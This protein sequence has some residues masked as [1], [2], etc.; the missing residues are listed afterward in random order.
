MLHKL[1][2]TLL[3]SFI[4]ITVFGQ[5]NIIPKPVSFEQNTDL[6]MLDQN[7]S[8]D[9]ETEI[10]Q[11][12]TYVNEFKTF[13]NNA[14]SRIEYKNVEAATN[15]DKVIRIGLL[16]SPNEK[17]G[18]EGYT[19]EVKANEVSLQANKPKGIYNG[20]QTFR[21][22]LPKEFE[23]TEMQ[24]GFGMIPGCKI[25][26]YPQYSWRG[27][28]L[29]VSRHF[30]K[31]EEVKAYIDVMARYKFNVLHW[32]LTD[33]EGWRIE[34][35]SLPKLTEVGAWRVPRHGK[36]GDGRS[37]PKEGEEATEGGFYTQEQI[38][39]IV[40][41]AG[42][43]NIM[44]IPE[45]D[46]PGHSMAALAAYPELSTKKEPKFVNPGAT[47]AE[48][49]AD[50]TFKM[51][52]ENTV[53]PIDENVY[54]FVD[55]V[56]TEVAQLFPAEYIHMGG[57]E[58]YHGFWE[59]DPEVQK[60]MR[61]KKIK[62][63]HE[64]QAYFV[65]RVQKI[66]ES[67]GKKMIGWDE[68]LDGGLSSN[69]AVMNWQGLERGVQASKNGN[70]VVFSP[71]VLTYIDYT[72]GDH[73]VELPIYL[74]LSLRKAYSFNPDVEGAVK[75]NILG[76]QTNLWTEQIKTLRHAFYM[77]YPR[78][79]ATVESLWSPQESK[80]WDNFVQRT[81]HHFSRLANA[82]VKASTAVYDPIIKVKMVEGKLMAKVTSDIANTSLHYTIDNS[83][84]DATTSKV[85][86]EFEVPEGELSLRVINLRNGRPI[87][88]MLS[89]QR[90]ELVRRAGIEKFQY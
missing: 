29:D 68:I 81:E 40:A 19:L 36:F 24:M 8:I 48:W 34:I 27:I 73:S 17:L 87:G 9:I 13:L 60:F 47:F 88:R 30:F 90:E 86:G 3:I 89:I 11:I 28:M 25:V 61:K 33:D 35:K 85:E 66:I 32:H 31:V 65:G 70:K 80:D 59:E 46:L 23:S 43:K 78:A 51:N 49:F 22:L 7:V 57:D 26:D 84:P 41:Y 83:F 82:G 10:P 6:F 69:A 58:C 62:D 53:N 56:M 63:S 50:G 1:L 67:K 2:T 64:L 14:G 55:K 39:D 18:E 74:D 12:K 75:E 42:R 20:L 5:H 72:Q 44:V 38:R 15:Q 16:D 4:G 71:K 54:A 37:Y 21:Q 79:F 45:I 52:I 76:G 77:T